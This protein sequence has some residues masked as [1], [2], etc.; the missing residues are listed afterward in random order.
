MS[1]YQETG[2]YNISVP[3]KYIQQQQALGNDPYSYEYVM[4]IYDQ[5]GRELGRTESLSKYVTS[6]GNLLLNNTTTYGGIEVDGINRSHTST[7][8]TQILNAATNEVVRDF[9]EEGYTVPHNLRTHISSVKTLM[10]DD[11]SP[12]FMVEG[13]ATD[14][15][16]E[17][18]EW[19]RKDDFQYG[20][21]NV[22]VWD[23][24]GHTI[25]DLYTS[26]DANGNWI[27]DSIPGS[28]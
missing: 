10:L 21:I 6:S 25:R 9:L 1:R 18:G 19:F 7:W 23:E 28:F 26:T 24:E 15:N 12:T 16:N 5:D 3:R 4:V 8:N 13:H 27:I 2:S 20:T 17:K 14:H 22:V 11:G